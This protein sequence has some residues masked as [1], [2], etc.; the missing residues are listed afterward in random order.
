MLPAGNA[1]F[2][3]EPPFIPGSEAANVVSVGAGVTQFRVGD[4][5]MS[6]LISA[7]YRTRQCCGGAVRSRAG[8]HEHGGGGVFRGAYSTAYHALLQRGRMKAGEW[9]LVRRRRALAR[10][11]RWRCSAPR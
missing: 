2:R 10:P 5:V 11:I 4:R 7:L 3:P 6:R 1:Q 8:E 9:V